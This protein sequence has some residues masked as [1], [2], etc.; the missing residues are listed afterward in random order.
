MNK[1]VNEKFPL[2]AKQILGFTDASLAIKRVV[3][4]TGLVILIIG[5]M[6]KLNLGL[7]AIYIALSALL[8]TAQHKKAGLLVTLILMLPLMILAIDAKFYELLYLFGCLLIGHSIVIKTK[9]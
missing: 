5:L 7:L 3:F 9:E 6:I 8:S 1:W 4:C 2:F